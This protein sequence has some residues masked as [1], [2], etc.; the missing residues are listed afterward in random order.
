MFWSYVSFSKFLT[1]FE[2][3]LVLLNVFELDF[4][5]TQVWI[6]SIIWNSWI[7]QVFSFWKLLSKVYSSEFRKNGRSEFC[8]GQRP[9][10]KRRPKGAKTEVIRKSSGWKSKGQRLS[11]LINGLK[12]S[13]KHSKVNCQWVIVHGPSTRS[14]SYRLKEE[15]HRSNSKVQMSNVRPEKLYI[16]SY[17]FKRLKVAKGG[18][19]WGKIVWF[20]LGLELSIEII[21]CAW[22]I[23]CLSDANH[24]SLIIN[25]F[26]KD[27]IQD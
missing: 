14:R 20:G 4:F 17:C 7:H 5:S 18:I 16:L 8:N 12:I 26:N 13:S 19:F 10:A 27:I 3:C 23:E 11:V 2:K 22:Y 15:G 1:G 9:E 6:A 24:R 25:N 21:A